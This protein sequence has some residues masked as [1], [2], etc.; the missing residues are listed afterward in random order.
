[1]EPTHI[2]AGRLQRDI[3]LPVYGPALIDVPG[4]ELLYAAAGFLLWGK[5]AGL[6]AR[7]GED[8]PNEWL[9]LFKSY[10]LDTRGIKILPE[11]IDL[12]NFLAYTDN[13][14]NHQTNPVAHFSRLGIPFPKI[15]LGYQPPQPEKSLTGE[16][17]ISQPRPADIP[18]DYLHARCVHLCGLDYSITSRMISAFREAQ[19]MTMT[20]DPQTYWMQPTHWKDVCLLL[21]GL[22]AFLPSEKELRSLF[23]GK[24]SDLVEMAEAIAAEG[25][26]L[27][28]VKRGPLGQLLYNGA[29]HK[30]WQ[31]PAYNVDMRD[32]TGAGDSFCGGFLGGYHNT[33]DPLQGVL[34]GNISAS[35]TVEGSGV[36]HILESHPGLA[37]MRLESLKDGVREL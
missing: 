4:G 26:E 6:L 31:I 28:V 21:K 25:C 30:C 2:F 18:T 29:S 11:E 3:L 34:H 37:K 24:S 23:W 7:V 27:V 14:I 35:L 32:P 20:L 16:A 10:G 15:L 1:M 19:V 13:F 5:G 36:F 8:Y 33:Y 22:T 17:D 9:S 12:R